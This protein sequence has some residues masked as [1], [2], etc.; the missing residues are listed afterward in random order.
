MRRGGQR[1]ARCVPLLAAAG[2]AARPVETP[3][4]LLAR[5]R[6]TTY[7]HYVAYVRGGDGRWY[8]CDDDSIVPVS[9]GKVRPPK[10]ARAHAT[11]HLRPA[12]PPPDPRPGRNL[13]SLPVGRQLPAAPPP[14]AL[15]ALTYPPPTRRCWQQTRTCCYGSATAPS[16]RQTPVTAAPAPPARS[17]APSRR[18]G[19]SRAAS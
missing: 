17:R 8:L 15:P 19:R 12:L 6:S 3:P 5:C 2:R 13:N 16:L 9:L 10:P 18:P 4:P 1:P 14:R 7:G 11:V